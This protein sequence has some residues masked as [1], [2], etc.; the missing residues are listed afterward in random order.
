MKFESQYIYFSHKNAF[1]NVCKIF[2]F[3]PQF[4]E[5]IDPV[6]WNVQYEMYDE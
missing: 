4:N 3:C 2:S 5:L 1:E 6:H